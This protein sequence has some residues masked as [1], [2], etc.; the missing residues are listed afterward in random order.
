MAGAAFLHFAVLGAVYAD[1]PARAK[2]M[3]TVASW[4]AYLV[5]PFCIMVGTKVDDVVRYLGYARAVAINKGY[6]AGPG[7]TCSMTGDGDERNVPEFVN[8]VRALVAEQ[9]LAAGVQPPDNSPFKGL[10]PFFSDDLYWVDANRLWVVLFCHAFFLGVFKD[11]M[12]AIVAKGAAAEVSRRHGTSCVQP[13]H[14]PLH[15]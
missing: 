1:S 2:L 14:L 13:Q 15:L 8:R 7:K 5:C 6:G 9:Y 11:F 4:T 12:E 10:S 3:Y